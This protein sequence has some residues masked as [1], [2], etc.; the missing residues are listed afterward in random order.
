VSEE[1]VTPDRDRPVLPAGY[2]LPE[3][4]DG[5]LA[6]ADVEARLVAA[7]SYWLATVWPDGRPHVVPRWGVWLD[8]RFWYDGAPTTRHARNLAAN[9]ACSL[10]LESGTEVVIVTGES[11]PA[12]APADSLGRRLA[13]G[14]EK[15]HASGYSPA[16]DAWDGDDGGGLRVLVPRQALAWFSF[17]GDATRFAFP[18]EGSAEG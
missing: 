9:P 12:R 13:Q 3:T 8:G 16:A 7:S 2:G 15:Y 6:W 17:P 1:S 14:F 10:N 4:T 5:L 18:P 11:R